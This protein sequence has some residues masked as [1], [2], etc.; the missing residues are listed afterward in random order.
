MIVLHVISSI[1][2]RGGGPSRSSQGLVAGLRAAGVDAWLM[3][4]S[5]GEEPWIKGVDKFIN[6]ESFKAALEKVK[7][8]IAHLHGIWQLELHR[9]ASL[10]RQRGIPYVIAPRGMLEP[11]SLKAKWLKKRIARFLYQDND[12]RK[13]AALHATAESEAEQFRKLGFKNPTIVSANGVNVPEGERFRIRKEECK[14][15]NG[16]EDKAQ[17]PRRALFVSRMHMKKGVLELVEAWAMVKPYGWECELV[18]TVNGDEE[19]QYETQVKARAQ[20]LGLENQFIFTGSL[21]D[22]AKWAAYARADLFVLPTYS[23]NFGLVVAEALWAGLPVITTKGTP[24]QELVIRHCG[25]WVDLPPRESLVAALREASNSPRE[26][27][28]AMGARGR[29][30]VE[31]KY[32]WS[33]I[34]KKMAVAYAQLLRADLSKGCL[35]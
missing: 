33:A 9:C 1:S 12:L 2:R 31:E 18:Y 26:T 25:W 16:S 19:R 3:T 20:E 32:Q 30:L 22:D 6:G 21:D 28:L 14:I 10:C 11:W 29:Q 23:E 5:H 15:E 34:G 4:L 24:W 8:D 7:P 13:A 27:L 35:K 17:M